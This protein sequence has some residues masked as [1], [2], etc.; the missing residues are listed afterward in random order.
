[1]NLNHLLVETC[2]CLVFAEDAQEKVGSWK[3][4]LTAPPPVPAAS[5]AKPAEGSPGP[6]GN[7]TIDRA[8]KRRAAQLR[9]LVLAED[10]TGLKPWF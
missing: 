8:G 7:L 9:V 4:S 5:P 3:M 2:S 10:K 1:M 6:E